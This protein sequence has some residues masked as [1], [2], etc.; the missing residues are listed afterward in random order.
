MKLRT[1]RHIRGNSMVELVLLVPVYALII[2]GAL[3]FGEI[4]LVQIQSHEANEYALYEPGDQGEHTAPG[5]GGAM[6]NEF[7]DRYYGELNLREIDEGSAP[8]RW[9]HADLLD[10]MTEEQYY[11]S[12]HGQYVFRGGRVVYEI[13]TQQRSWRSWQGQYVLNHQILDGDVPELIDE[14]MIGYMDRHRVETQFGF[15]PGYITLSILHQLEAVDIPTGYQAA[16]RLDLHREV[17][18]KYGRPHAPI[19]SLTRR[20]GD[21]EGIMEDFPNFNDTDEF[22]E[23]N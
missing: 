9:E 18:R 8:G 10:E 3:L 2:A 13:N 6:K 16:R 14:T 22:W 23:P 12:A 17:D 5:Q 7:W 1:H 20:F 21:G 4:A 11:T 19:E 15:D